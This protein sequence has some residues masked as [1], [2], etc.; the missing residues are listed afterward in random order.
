MAISKLQA[1]S[2]NLADT[3]AFTGTVS[4][5]GSNILE[6]VPLQQ[7]G[8]NVTINGT[9]YSTTNVTAEQLLTTS[10]ADVNGSSVSYTPPSGA[11]AVIY[12]YSC[13]FGYG[14]TYTIAHFAFY[15]DS[16]EVTAARQTLA[17]SQYPQMAVVFRHIIPIGGSADTATGRQATW[18]TAKTLKVQAREYGGTNEARLFRNLHWDGAS[19]QTEIRKPTLLIT[20]VG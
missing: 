6:Q 11:V 3:Y 7:D 1:A 13:M 12:E 8:E 15:I 19:N 5:A 18:T 20:A 16:D 2:L 17:T 14:D 10:Y 4:G 9:T